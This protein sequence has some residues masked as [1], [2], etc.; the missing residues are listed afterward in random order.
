MKSTNAFTVSEV[1]EMLQVHRR[2]VQRW[3]QRGLLPAYRVG[4][5]LLRIPAQALEDFLRDGTHDRRP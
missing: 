5:T 4:P 3:I 1:A 2:T